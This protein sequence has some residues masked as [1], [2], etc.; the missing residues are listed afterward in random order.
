M[1]NV[2]FK[3]NKILITGATGFIGSNLLRRL[4]KEKQTD[5]RILVRPTSDLHLIKDCS[6]EKI[7]GDITDLNSIKGILDDVDIVIHGAA[8]VSMGGNYKKIKQTNFE[9]LK[10]ILTLASQNK[11]LKRFIFLSSI[12][13]YGF[14]NTKL[15]NENNPIKKFGWP[16][17][18]SKIDAEKIALEFAHKFNIPIVITRLGD[19]L[20]YESTWLKSS[21]SLIKEK[22]IILVNNGTGLMNYIWI[23]DLIDALLVIIDN[24]NSNEK[25]FNITSGHTITFDKYFKDLCKILNYKEPRSIPFFLAY[26]GTLVNEIFQKT[27][28]LS[29]E[30]TKNAIKYTTCAKT[31]NIDKAK[32]NFAWEPKIFYDNIMHRFQKYLTT[33]KK[34]Y[35]KEKNKQ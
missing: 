30:K 18:D 11:K 2:N 4:C 14:I 32:K 25:I 3:K 19:V 5:I 13:V 20:G 23:E 28:S 10:N 31:I 12:A 26:L 15:I 33:G 1:D 35:N 6:F 27:L 21:V 29:T 16:Y 9:G 34:I 24:P 22:K 17:A 8:H 7:L